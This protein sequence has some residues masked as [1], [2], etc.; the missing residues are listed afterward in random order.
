M[1]DGCS[2]TTPPTH[3]RPPPPV[4]SFSAHISWHL[5]PIAD[6]NRPGNHAVH[7]GPGRDGRSTPPG[8]QRYGTE[9][10]GNHRQPLPPPRSN[11]AGGVRTG[12]SSQQHPRQSHRHNHSQST[13]EGGQF[14]GRIGRPLS[15]PAMH[16][17]RGGGSSRSGVSGNARASPL[18][19]TGQGTPARGSPLVPRGSPVQG[20]PLPASAGSPL[21]VGSRASPGTGDAGWGSRYSGADGSEGVGGESNGWGG[22]G[23]RARGPVIT[24]RLVSLKAEFLELHDMLLESDFQW[25]ESQRYREVLQRQLDQLMLVPHRHR[26][27]L[28]PPR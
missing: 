19:A 26:D 6:S 16:L 1:D 24:D 2:L 28:P 9:S 11:G 7:R 18:S 8:D 13:G 3:S 20:S 14:M 25:E 21:A 22:G 15:H 17:E 5:T 10:G 4:I 27:S 23:R 12:A